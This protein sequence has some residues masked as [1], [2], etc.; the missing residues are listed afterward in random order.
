[1]AVQSTVLRLSRSIGL[2][3]VAVVPYRASFH[4]QE[5]H[6]HEKSGQPQR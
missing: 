4:Q 6:W 3:P 1:M 2:L 5:K